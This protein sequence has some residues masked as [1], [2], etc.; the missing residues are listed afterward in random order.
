MSSSPTSS[1]S[2]DP[3]VAP[4]QVF[5]QLLDVCVPADVLLGTGS[6]TVRQCLALDRNSLLELTQSAGEDLMLDVRGVQLARGEIVIVEDSA[7][8]R[9]TEISAPPPP[10]AVE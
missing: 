6:V 3:D 1:S 7:A 4:A 9:I 8:L 5:Q 10:R 2:S